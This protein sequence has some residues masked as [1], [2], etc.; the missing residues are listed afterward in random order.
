MNSF[1]FQVLTRD[2]VSKPMATTQ[3]IM[4]LATVRQASW[5]QRPPVAPP[6]LMR[7][8]GLGTSP[9]MSTAITPAFNWRVKWSEK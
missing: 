8:V 5:T 4:P 6:P 1:P 7:T 2:M 9:H 3:S